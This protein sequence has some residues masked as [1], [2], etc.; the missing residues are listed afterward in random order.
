MAANPTILRPELT[1]LAP[2]NAGLTLAEV[3]ARKG[4]TRV[5]KLGSNENPAG[6]DPAVVDALE[7]AMRSIGAYPDPVGRNLVA[8][9]AEKHGWPQDKFVLGNGSEDLLAVLARAVLRPGDKVVTLYPSFPLHE[10][11][12]RLMGAEVIRIGLDAEGMIDLP[13]LLDAVAKPV[14][15]V[16]FANPM[17]P[18][19]VWLQPADLRRVLAAVHP[20]AITCVDEAYHEYASGPDYVSAEEQL[21]TYARPLVILRTFS[22]AWGLAGLR[23]GYA[24]TNSD[25][26][27]QGFDLAR[28]PFNVNLMAQIAAE[29]ALDHPDAVDRAVAL[30]RIERTRVAKAISDMGMRVLPSRGNFLFFDAGQ[31]SSMIAERLLDHGV[32]VKPWRQE[33]YESWL[34]VSI[35]SIMDND[36]FLMALARIREAA[37][38]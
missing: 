13:A 36:Q 35:G 30:V 24:M 1:N 19:G 4:V 20:E 21:A 23:I 16:L 2:Y 38:G 3:A 11:Y 7:N 14:R 32:I 12:A 26:L 31:P 18:A 34:R 25:Q 5:A 17:N 8:R 6:T 27:R 37:I 33:G 22:K 9:L 10:D 28:T 29:A 15:L